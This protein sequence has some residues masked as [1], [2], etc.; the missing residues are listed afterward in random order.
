MYSASLSTRPAQIAAVSCEGTGAGNI[1][2]NPGVGKLSIRRSSV[3]IV[4]GQ[5]AGCL[6]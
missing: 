2:Q 4:P 3:I 5:I 1:V 6:S